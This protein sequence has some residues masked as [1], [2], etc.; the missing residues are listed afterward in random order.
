MYRRHRYILLDPCRVIARDNDPPER[1][2]DFF[3]ARDFENKSIDELLEEAGIDNYRI[4]Y[5]RKKVILRRSDFFKFAEHI[6][7][8]IFD[9]FLL[10]GWLFV[11]EA[12]DGADSGT[13]A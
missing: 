1:E 7:E 9:A 3:A 10:N 6:R 12:D 13:E 5:T 8:L 4:D 2:I 11:Q